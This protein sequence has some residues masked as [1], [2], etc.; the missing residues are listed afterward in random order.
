MKTLK[1]HKMQGTGNDFVVL[2]NRN[3]KLSENEI[4]RLTPQ[5]CDR[6]YGIGADGLLQLEISQKKGVDFTMIYRNADGS[7]AGMCG[8]GARCLAMFAAHHGFKD[9]VSFNVHNAVYKATIN[10]A[11][12]LVIVH[13]PDIEPPNWIEI[14]NHKLIQVYPNTEHVVCLTA[15]HALEEEQDLIDL[16]TTIRNADVLKPQGTNVNFVHIQQDNSILLQTYERGVEN[17]TL[18]CGTGAIASAIAVHFVSGSEA[19]ESSIAVLVKG[20]ELEVNFTF[21]SEFNS[22]K[23]VTLKGPARFVYEGTIHI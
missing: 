22:Y 21:D 13:F 11:E 20:G 23:N 5:L 10:K 4:I 8:N 15:K 6:K 18:A 12:E 19:G 9:R 16:G 3:L 1:F 7:D 2:D 14:D 17:L